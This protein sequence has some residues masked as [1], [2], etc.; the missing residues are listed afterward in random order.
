MKYNITD[1]VTVRVSRRGCEKFFNRCSD[2]GIRLSGVCNDGYGVVC[3]MSSADFRRI[4][5]C[6]RGIGVHVSII[7]KSGLG[8][9]LKHRRKRRA[10]FIGGAAALLI[11]F[12]LT[13]CIWVIDV[14]GNEKIPDKVILSSIEKHGLKVGSL[15]YG[16]DIKKLQNEV[17]IDLDSLSWLWVDIDGTRA[18]VKVR[19]KELG[20]ES[21]NR[22]GAYNM[23]ASHSGYVTDIVAK[24]GRKVIERGDVVAEGDL[25]ISGISATNF[26]GN[27]YIHSQG[28]VTAQTWRKKSGEYHHTKTEFKKT[29][30]KV[31][32]RTVNFFGFDVKLYLSKK[33]GF[34]LYEESKKSSQMKILG[35]IYLPVSFTTDTFCEIIR[36][37]KKITDA[38]AVSAAVNSLT[39]QIEGERSEGAVTVKREY[40]YQKLENGDVF[41]TVTVESE[42]NIARPVK[43]EVDKTEDSNFGKDT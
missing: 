1:S 16:H 42:E 31:K 7:R 19:E 43:I 21:E 26:K 25:L 14:T 30:K 33:T 8:L 10:F 20:V 22:D 39:A 36:E 4:R 34:E 29:G 24:S 27:R 13:S 6:A 35:N 41:V 12:Y 17:L 3:R 9:Y 28:T 2:C 38:D 11:M 32:K 15:R 37:D 23:V 5:P 40:E 18:V